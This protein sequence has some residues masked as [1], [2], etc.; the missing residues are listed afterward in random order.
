MLVRYAAEDKRPGT[1]SRSCGEGDLIRE[2]A[3]E[4][5]G[6]PR[7]PRGISVG[8]GGNLTRTTGEGRYRP[9]R[10]GYR[11]SEREQFKRRAGRRLGQTAR[12]RSARGGPGARRSSARSSGLI[13][14]GIS[15]ARELQG[16][17]ELGRQSW[18]SPLPLGGRFGIR[19][20]YLCGQGRAEARFPPRPVSSAPRPFVRSTPSS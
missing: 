4:S 13:G 15:R 10:F 1:S 19:V 5:R 8:Y 9:P 2:S 3:R 12:P 7:P 17:A 6:E 14:D 18:T 16:R 11:I 20:R